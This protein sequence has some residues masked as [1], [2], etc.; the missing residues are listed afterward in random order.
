M[1]ETIFFCSLAVGEDALLL[2]PLPFSSLL[3]LPGLAAA[4]MD[5]TS[6]CLSC[7][8]EPSKGTLVIEGLCIDAG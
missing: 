6:E 5:T 1:G 3:L 7:C 2:L 8:C 4:G